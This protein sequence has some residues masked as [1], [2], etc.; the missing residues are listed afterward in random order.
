MVHIAA[1]VILLVAVAAANLA[2]ATVTSDTVLELKNPESERPGVP[3]ASGVSRA[4]IRLDDAAASINA[5]GQALDQPEVIPNWRLH[6]LRRTVAIGLQRLGCRL[7]VI[8]AVLGHVSGSRAGIVGIYQRHSYDA[9][10]RQALDAWAAHVVGL[11]EGEPAH[12]IV[13]LRAASDTGTTEG[14]AG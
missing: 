5:D 11:V 3:A 13:P 9:E 2:G 12:N 14:A 4:K 1:S 7:E 6:D 8:E 10:K